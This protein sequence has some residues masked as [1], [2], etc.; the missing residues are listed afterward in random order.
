MVGL[1]Y[2]DRE[3]D[4]EAKK[5]KTLTYEND[6][7]E[8]NAEIDAGHVCKID[9]EMFYYWLEVL[10]PVYM[11]QKRLIDIDGKMTEKNCSFGF[12]EGGPVID[13]WE[14]GEEYFGKQRPQQPMVRISYN[15]EI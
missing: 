9:E 2:Q 8:F 1:Y 15:G 14:E 3:T 6:F 5:M 11:G 4:K 13:F 7:T 12:A 10:P